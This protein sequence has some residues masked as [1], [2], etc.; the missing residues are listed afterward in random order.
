LESSVFSRTSRRRFACLLPVLVF[1]ALR[2]LSHAH[3]TPLPWTSGV[4][5]GEGLDDVLQTIRIVYTGSADLR[6]AVPVALATPT[7]RVTLLD[8][9][10]DRGALLAIGHSRAPPRS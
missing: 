9:R 7:G 2:S 8:L 10:L 3:P 4:F 6:H 1:L 5:D